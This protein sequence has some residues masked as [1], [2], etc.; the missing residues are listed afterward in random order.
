MNQTERRYAIDRVKQIQKGHLDL[1]REHVKANTKPTP[2]DEDKLEQIRS[3]SA[4]LR[5]ERAIANVNGYRAAPDLFD[6]F[7]F[8]GEAK[9]EE[10]NATLK[11]EGEQRSQLILQEA[12]K[13]ID[14]FQ[15]RNI[16][17]T[18]ALALIDAFARGKF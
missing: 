9:R 17:S 6:V 12:Q 2:S 7:E 4:K 3:G 16:E 14:S 1:V 10:A 18:A 15:L 8:P 13:L 11:A 5:R